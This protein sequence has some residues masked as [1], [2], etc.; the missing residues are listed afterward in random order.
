MRVLTYTKGDAVILMDGDLEDPPELIVQFIDKW[1]EGY[2][3]IYGVKKT[4]Q[5]NIIKKC[6]FK[7]FYKIFTSISNVRIDQQAGMFSLLDKKAINK[8]KQCKEK[9]KYYVGLRFFL[10]MK[11]YKIEYSRQGR[12]SGKPKQTYKKLIRYAFDAFFSFS[13]FPIRLLTLF[14]MVIVIVTPLISLILLIARLSSLHF[15]IFH[16]FPP[17]WTTLVLLSLFILGAQVIFMGVLG[18]YIAS[19]SR[20]KKN[21]SKIACFRSKVEIFFVNYALFFVKQG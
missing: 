20:A 9:N 10:G 12:Y 6:F 8:L 15:G 17:G 11:Q 2:D 5:V 3:V 16:Q 14:G 1:R 18:E 4:R 19:D 7:L 13:F 21:F